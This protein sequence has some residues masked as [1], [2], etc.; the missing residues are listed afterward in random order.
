VPSIHDESQLTAVGTVGCACRHP[1]G[2]TAPAV[3]RPD[4]SAIGH[5]TRS[6]DGTNHRRAKDV[7][8][9][10]NLPVGEAPAAPVGPNAGWYNSRPAHGTPHKRCCSR[11][12]SSGSGAQPPRP[13]TMRVPSALSW[14]S[15]RP[16]RDGTQ[17]PGR[18]VLAARREAAAAIAAQPA[19][20]Y[21]PQLVQGFP[22]D[23]RRRGPSVHGGCRHA[24]HWNP[25]EITE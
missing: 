25:T 24:W 17:P 1:A 21:V 20:G 8:R 6:A 12:R 15:H 3:K 19:P 18:W 10:S 13:A 7:A 23:V 11:C 14:K 2:A 5:A 22:L 4:V 9:Q 16:E